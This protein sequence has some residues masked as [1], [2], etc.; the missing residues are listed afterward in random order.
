VLSVI[1]GILVVGGL[2]LQGDGRSD[3]SAEMQEMTQLQSR[4]I[5][6]NLSDADLDRLKAAYDAA[7]L[8]K[9]K[10][11]GWRTTDENEI[12]RIFGLYSLATALPPAAGPRAQLQNT[13]R[14]PRETYLNGSMSISSISTLIPSWNSIAA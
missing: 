5:A 11:D 14:A 13:I 10:F 3:F 6:N 8:R 2:F 7:K 4:M 9:T 1:T 12:T